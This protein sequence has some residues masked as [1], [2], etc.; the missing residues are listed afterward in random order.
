[1]QIGNDL[2]DEILEIIAAVEN[3]KLV[4][5]K[6]NQGTRVAQAPDEYLA[7]TR[8]YVVSKLVAVAVIN[9]LEVIDIE[10]SDVQRLL[11][12]VIKFN[13]WTSADDSD[14][15]SVREALALARKAEKNHK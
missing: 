8:Q 6:P 10:H 7:K 5:A 9:P 12:S 3:Q 15:D 4:S 13:A 2:P 1:M 11:A 14:Y